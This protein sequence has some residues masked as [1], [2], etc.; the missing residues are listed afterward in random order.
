MS[1][2]PAPALGN[3]VTTPETDEIRITRFFRA[4]AELAYRAWTT[5]TMLVHWFGCA[6]FTTISATADAREGGAWRVVMR[7]PEGIDFPAFGRYIELVAP[8]RI[9]MTHQ[10]EKQV[11][12]VNPA[13]HETRVTVTLHPENGGTRLEFRQTGLAS[14]ASRDS[15][16]GGWCD[17]L[18]AL[19][20]RIAE[21]RFR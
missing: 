15:H 17:S 9:V 20:A 4:P 6:A 13:R 11:V 16:I 7:S 12:E 21:E 2:A 19:H 5:P 1:L 14:T 8:K 10:W 18:D 3:I